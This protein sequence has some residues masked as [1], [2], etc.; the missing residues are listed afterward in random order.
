[1]NIVATKRW[2]LALAFVWGTLI[3]ACAPTQPTATAAPTRPTTPSAPGEEQV[4]EV[5]ARAYQFEPSEI[6]VSVN[7]PVRFVVRSAD[8]DHTFD[9]KADRQAQ[10][11]LV[12]LAVPAGRTVETTYTFEET[13]TYYLYCMLHEAQGMTGSIEVTP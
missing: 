7:R 1:M 13:G 4:I 3:A 5:V 9:I 11:M 12:N 6:Q 10:E 8:I 2:T